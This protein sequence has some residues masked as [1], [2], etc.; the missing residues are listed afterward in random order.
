LQGWRWG[1]GALRKNLMATIPTRVCWLYLLVPLLATPAA[2]EQRAHVAARIGGQPV[3]TAEVDREFHRAYGQHPLPGE[4]RASAWQAARQQVIDRHLVMAYLARTGQAASESDIDLALAQLE[5]DLQSQMLTLADHLQSTSLTL[6]ELRAALAWK[7]SWN[8]YLKK[9][10][11]G[12]NLQKYFERHKREFDGTRLRVAHILWKLPAPADDAAR[13]AAVQK[14]T[15][16]R[17]E[18][19]AGRLSF[20]AA[21]K[22]HS[23]APTASRGGDLGWIERHQPQPEAF[24]RAAFALQKGEVSPPVESPFGIHLISVLEIQE[25]QGKWQDVEPELSRAVTVYLFRWLADKE[26]SQADIEYLPVNP[27]PGSSPK[28]EPAR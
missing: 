17:D 8:S 16:V 4:A 19:V 5:K 1:D 13:A 14:A 25:G 24:S 10:L 22:A 2:A 3:S 20:A 7:I 23:E 26:R 18:I 28:P 11:T 12:G 9:H 6:A 27:P 21:A 15:Q